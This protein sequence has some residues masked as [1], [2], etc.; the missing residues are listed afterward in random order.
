MQ[1]SFTWSAWRVSEEW[2]GRVNIFSTHFL[3]PTRDDPTHSLPC[4]H[5]YDYSRGGVWWDRERVRDGE[6]H[7]WQF[8][9]SGAQ[10]TSRSP[11]CLLVPAEGRPLFWGKW[12][13][14]YMICLFWGVYVESLLYVSWLKHVLVWKVVSMKP[15]LLQFKK[16]LS[17]VQ[18]FNC[19]RN[20]RL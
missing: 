16:K 18:G 6:H 14:E 13:W 11:T 1:I 15:K 5:D 8:S 4:S 3:P 20:K 10:I 7:E 17:L 9:A 12:T 2:V 19:K